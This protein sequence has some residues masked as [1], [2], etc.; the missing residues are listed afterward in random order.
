MVV[1]I[2]DKKT[3]QQL[4]MDSELTIEKAK[5]TIRQKEAVQGQGR[6]LDCERKKTESL[7]ELE[8]VIAELQTSIDELASRD[9]GRGR[10]GRL[11]PQAGA[12]SRPVA[13]KSATCTR[14]GYGQH[15]SG[16]R[17]P[18]ADNRCHICNRKGHFSSK[19][20]SK[21]AAP[22]TIS[23]VDSPQPEIT[24]LDTVS[25]CAS[26][27]WV[28]TVSMLNHTVEF[29]IDTGAAVDYHRGNIFRAQTTKAVPS[30][31]KALWTGPTKAGGARCFSSG[32]SMPTKSRSNRCFMSSEV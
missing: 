2:L 22:T 7:E 28:T 12:S 3:S 19:C 6:K 27:S 15:S 8:K 32:S 1:G 18:A 9:K 13:T 26:T 4:K 31:E 29:K 25:D 14:C 5:K 17:C 24:Y 10:K 23:E 21:T 20:F 30:Q 11:W 16:E